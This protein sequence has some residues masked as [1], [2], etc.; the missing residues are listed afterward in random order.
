MCRVN[1]LEVLA[2]TDDLYSERSREALAGKAG[3]E[4]YEVQ[5]FYEKMFLAQGYR[6]T[7]LSF[8]IDHEGDYLYPRRPEDFDPD[9]WRSVEGPRLLFGRDSAETRRQKMKG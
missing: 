3:A 4:L 1:G 5:T 7:Y 6:I 8:V 2:C 9:Y